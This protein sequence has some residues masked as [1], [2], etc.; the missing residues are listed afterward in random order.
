MVQNT[1]VSL[2]HHP[3]STVSS[4]APLFTKFAVDSAIL[5]MAEEDTTSDLSKLIPFIQKDLG[6][7]SPS[8]EDAQAVKTIAHAVALRAARLSGAAIGATVIHTNRLNAPGSAPGPKSSG[9]IVQDITNL[10]ITEAATST[11]AKLADTAGLKVNE[12]E[13]VDI[14]VDGS[15]VEFYPRFQDTMRE[16]LRVL[17]EIGVAGER[18]IRIG[19]ARDG[20]GVG[21]ALIALVAA[22]MEKRRAP[23][24]Y[25]GELRTTHLS[26][27]KRD[28]S[29]VGTSESTVP[30][31]IT[32]GTEQPVK[33][34]TEET[35]P[36]AVV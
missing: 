30:E 24:D 27:H 7:P 17:P 10:K 35:V 19:I 21:A 13:V 33:P 29:A 16:A 22:E 14:G 1:T 2:F 20:S 15:L 4:T 11:I 12:D 9:A 8:L 34:V 23:K 32:I 26:H 6:V 28:F 25:I 36:A 5:S 18:R 3:D 31:H